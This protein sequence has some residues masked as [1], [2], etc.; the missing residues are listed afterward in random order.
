MLGR[1]CMGIFVAWIVFVSS[2]SR[3]ADDVVAP[4]TYLVGLAARDIT[5]DYPIRLSGFGFRRTESEGVTARIY[6]RA[7]A[8]GSDEDGPALLITVDTT[9]IADAIVGQLAVRLKPLGVT[10]EKLVVTGTHTH[11][12]PMLRGVLPTLFGEP[13][14]PGHQAHIDRY[15]A[16]FTDHLEEVA[17]VALRDRQPAKLFWGVGAVAFA[18]NRRSANG[19]I[20]HDLPVLAVKSRSGKLR[21][22]LTTY[23]CHAVTL[24]HNFIGGDWPGFAAEALERQFPGAVAMISIGCGADQNPTSGV[25]GDKVDVARGQGAELA[26]EVAAV[27]NGAL[28]PVAGSLTARQ[29]RIDLPLAELPQRSHWE[30][31]VPKGSYIGYHAQVQLATLD[32]G[33]SLP[34]KI[35]YPVTTWTFGDSLA[36]VFLPGE[37][38][39]DY[40]LRLKRELD[41]S[42]LW[43]MAY[44]N[45]TPCYIPSERVLKEGGYEGAAAMTYYNKPAKFATGIEQ[46]IIDAVH[47]LVPDEFNA[48]QKGALDAGPLPLSP[49]QSVQRLQVPAD[50]NVQIVAAEPLTTDPVAIDFGPDGALWA[51]EMHDYPSGLHGNFEP[52]GR[53]RILRDDD[54]DGIYDRSTIFLDRLPFPTGVTVWRKGVLVCTAPDI[55]YA[56]DTDGD[57]RADVRRV[58]FSGFGT[59]NY[60]ARVNS[61]SYGLDGWV[62]GACGLFGGSIRSHMTEET[63]ELGNRDFRIDPDRGLIEP[64][65]GRTQQGRVRTDDG[66]WFGCNNSQPILHYPLL[67]DDSRPGLTAPPLVVNTPPTAERQLL[68]PRL[69]E[70]QRFKLSG[71]A[72]R[73]TAA[74]GL[75]IYRDD[76]LGHDLSGN[77]VICEPV[78]LLLHRRL[79]LP[80]GVL[81]DAVRAQGEEQ[82]ELVTSTDNW[83]RPVQARTG[84][85]GGLWI[86]DMSRAVIEHP[87]WIPEEVRAKLDVRAGENQGRI[88]RLLPADRGARPTPKLSQMTSVQLIDTLRSPNGTVRDLAQQMLL[89]RD[90][91]SAASDIERLALADGPPPSRAAALWVLARWR[92][93]NEGTLKASLTSAEP[94]LRRQ[95]ARVLAMHAAEFTEATALV[96]LLRRESDPQVLLEVVEALRQIPAPDRPQWLARLYRA[97]LDDPY[98]KFATLRAVPADEWAASVSAAM[99]GT[100]LS[101]AAL[102]PLLSVSLAA[103][104]AAALNKLLPQILS[105]SA[106]MTWSRWPLIEQLAIA[107]QRSPEEANAWLGPEL[108]ARLSTIV[109]EARRQFAGEQINE[110]TR[111]DIAGLLGL[112]PGQRAGDVELLA[113]RLSPQASPALQSRLIAVLDRSRDE[114][115]PRLLLDRWTSLGPAA[116]TD[117]LDKLVSRPASAHLL[118]DAIA[119][120]RLPIGQ[121]DAARRQTLL[122]HPNEQLRSRAMAVLQSASNTPRAEVL[123]QYRSVLA[124]TGDAQRGRETYRKRCAVCHVWE[125]EGHSAGPDLGEARNK[126]WSALLVALLDPNQAVDQRYA[127]YVVLTTDGQTLHGLLAAETPTSITLKGQEAKLTTL[128][129]QDIE[130]LTSSGRSLMPEGLE[131]D[132]APQDLADLFALL[133]QRT[134]SGESDAPALTDVA[135]Q[136]LDDS[137]PRPEREALIAKN[138]DRAAE[139]I[140]ALVTEMGSDRKEEYRRIPWIWRVAVAAGKKNDAAQVRS[141]LQASLPLAEASLADWQAVVVGGGVINGISQ[142]GAWP[143][144][145]IAEIIGNDTPLKTRWRHSLAEALAMSQNAITPT[146]TRYDALRIIAMDGWG[147]RGAELSQYLAADAHAELQMGAVSALVDIPDPPATTA[148]IEHLADLKPKNRE[149][150][151]DGLLRSEDRMLVLLEAIAGG[152]VT[153]DQ[154]G[155]SR[156][157]RL[158]EASFPRVQQRA[159]LLLK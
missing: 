62:Y 9:G 90:D 132:V 111:I 134:T 154:L 15:T 110:K 117:V 150:A 61:L 6:A 116:K 85:D 81:L 34:T 94:R 64:L 152:R 71:P 48:P 136:I 54:G 4:A 16:E 112:E 42:R 142:A 147:R 133:T 113:A 86:V 24:S 59:E 65:T 35:D 120:N 93:L 97:H 146:G 157:Q 38:V 100:A 159:K 89:W 22:I 13:I 91:R 104:D 10:R 33:E 57:D 46:Q 87:R 82:A 77:A 127:D 26:A 1:W 108:T 17:L 101:N 103:N 88:L 72:G 119:E 158:L 67:T 73:V 68:F 43:L 139:L 80:R 143:H 70:Y 39:V 28:R 20:D 40:S 96:G 153:A 129:R 151:L 126:S 145:R 155:E 135:R 11:T 45:D 121:I 128:A 105:I 56:E 58:L 37:V 7:L 51:C 125:G 18:K 75:G 30:S 137:K 156:R 52:G 140:M 3:G 27:L 19:P 31:L 5:P 92:L 69:A 84:P 74:C 131:K 76:W 83:F 109:A 99:H 79:L 14:P 115:A 138:A 25:T 29:E 47:R 63:I 95:A 44:A 98:L 102:E 8:V 114:K 66:D 32:R 144:E 53:V 149:L 122:Q 41:R 36:M 78:N 2:M 23:A 141:V 12:A 55:L 50:W 124:L 118:L 49:R 60:Q 130:R 107:R 21:G 148:L 106:S 123:A